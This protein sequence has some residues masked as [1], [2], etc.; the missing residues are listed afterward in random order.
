MVRNVV[1]MWRKKT[2]EGLKTFLFF[3]WALTF[4]IWLFHFY[5]ETLEILKFLAII[6]I[7][8]G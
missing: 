5:F 1:G 2:L 7:I 4:L 6:K 3:K 8:M